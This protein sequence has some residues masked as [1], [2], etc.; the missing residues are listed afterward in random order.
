M[1]TVSFSDQKV[2][3]LLNKDFVNTFTNTTGDPTAGKSIWHQPDDLPGRCSRGVGGQN[4]QTIFMTPEGEIFHAANGFLSAEDLLEEAQFAKDLF[5]QMEGSEGS[6]NGLVRQ[7]HE[8]RL[9]ELGYDADQIE[10]AKS[11]RPF[12]TFD[13]VTETEPGNIFAGKTKKEIL[14]SHVFSIKHPMM[15]Y[16][17]FEKDPTPLV[18]K[19][20]SSFVSTNSD[21]RTPA[22]RSETLDDEPA[23]KNK[24]PAKSD[25]I[26][27]LLE[28]MKNRR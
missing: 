2:R 24:R 26:S 10:A 21:G 15:D 19:G 12:A 3:S 7:A 1:R 9:E 14:M 25:E 13:L 4:V 16:R 8:D 6:V 20:K 5:A 22:N 17:K 27:D 23:N 28:K 18:G 11:G